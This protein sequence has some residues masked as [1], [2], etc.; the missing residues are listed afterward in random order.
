M[1]KFIKVIGGG[2]NFKGFYATS[3]S[4]VMD[5]IATILVIVPSSVSHS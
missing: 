1:I 3:M 4:I 5:F 2:G